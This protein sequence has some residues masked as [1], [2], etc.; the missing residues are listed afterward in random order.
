M[1]RK[2]LTNID[3]NK[4]E[5]QNVV[6][7]KLATAPSTPSEGQIYYNTGDKRWYIRQDAAWKD[8]T[9]RLDDILSNTNAVTI[10]DN[11]DGTLQFEIANANS[12]NP[13]LMTSA[14][15]D[16]LTNATTVSTPNTIVE[17]DANGD[18]NFN[19]ITI[20]SAP[21]NPNHI[22]TK[23]YVDNLVSG[24]VNIVG[25]I[26]CSGDPVYPAADKGDAYI[27]SV[28][29]KIG[30]GS[31]ELVEAGDMIIATAGNAGG[32]QAA[33]GNSWV[34]VQSNMD[35]ATETIAG[36]I[37]IS[38]QDEADAGTD[39][40]SAITPLKMA[41]Y[42]ATQIGNTGAYAANIGDATNTT[43][44]VSH[45][46]ASQDVTVQVRENATNEYVEAGMEAPNATTVII[47]FAL[48][49]AIDAYR[50]IIKS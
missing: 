14:H 46:L 19:Q 47:R 26:D 1:A 5:I 43:F 40:T 24:G 28:A 8:I 15:Y 45:G 12:T 20:D 10:T 22:A 49:P 23:S 39:D 25:Q 16:D 37:R 27:V 21:T 7:H 4:N 29:G 36:K 35:A 6:I 38:T 32:T 13:G 33:V 41:T 9:G 42:V 3:L 34:I 50:V 18:S 30:G 48:A 17:R 31:G 11:G 44:T 2:F